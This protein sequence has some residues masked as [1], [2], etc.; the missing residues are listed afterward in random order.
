MKQ[1]VLA[2]VFV[3]LAGAAAQAQSVPPLVNYQGMLTDA[4]GKAQTGTKKLEFN[5]YDA[6]TGGSKVW[7]PQV[8]DSVPLVNGMFNVIL[9]PTDNT[10]Q[11]RPL[12][13]AFTAKDRYFG[14]KVNDGTELTPRQQI[15]STPYAIK[16]EKT[17]KILQV[18]HSQTNEFISSDQ[19]IPWDDTIPQQTEGVEVLTVTITPT[20][21]SNL[22][23][24]EAAVHATEKDNTAD[25]LILALFGNSD[26]DAIA[27]AVGDTNVVR[28]SLQTI[29][30]T[31]IMTAGT[32]SQI[33]FKLR[34]GLQAVPI[35]INAPSLAVF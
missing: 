24:I 11:K 6:A 34:A 4:S 2:M 1:M 15:L 7:G 16:A 14:L 9:G 27:T 32:T 29:P 21:A 20:D 5:L 3:L 30:F 33:T 35:T 17:G 26:S 31:H 18:V 13:E 25:R 12:T 19:A 8:F 28:D 10:E 23:L 22:L